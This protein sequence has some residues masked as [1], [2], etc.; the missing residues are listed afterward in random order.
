MKYAFSVL[1][2][3]SAVCG[4]VSGRLGEMSGAVAAAGE[5]TVSLALILCGMMMLWCG[6]TQI[7]RE[8]GDDVRLSRLLRRI[9]SPLF[10][11]LKDE[12]AWN[13]VTLNLSA[14]MLGLGNAATPYGMEAARLLAN[15][16]NGKAGLRALAM[17][18][19]LNNSGLQLI[20]ATV[21][22][23]RTAAGSAEPAAFWG[24][25]LLASAAAT[26]VAVLLL[27]VLQKGEDLWKKQRQ[28]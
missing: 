3:A 13:A 10:P 18:L 21:I 7:L 26:I 5:R 15:F 27:S 9:L 28:S 4:M 16:T 8:T 17:L 12:A 2:I 24:A 11:G 1:V 6:L 19:V 22:A 20:P 25:E 23:L 14:N